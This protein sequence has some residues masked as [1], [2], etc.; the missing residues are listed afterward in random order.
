MNPP[1]TLEALRRRA[2]Q[3]DATPRHDEAVAAYERLL[4][5]QPAW[6]DG[7][8]NLGQ[9]QW[10]AR[11]FDAALQSYRQALDIGIGQPEEVHLN[12]SVI[13]AR[14]LGRIHE[15]VRELEAALACNPRYLPALLN[16]GNVCE[17]RGDRD[18]ARQCYEEA[19]RV[20]PTQALALSR[21]PNLQTLRDAEDPLI[22]R[23]DAALH[24]AGRSPAECADLGF[25][26]GKALD[27]VGRYDEAFAAYQ[28]ANQASRD[29][30]GGVRYDAAAH[31]R[32]VDRLIAAFACPAARPASSAGC[33]PPIFIC[34]MFRS[35]S[36]LI[37]QVLASH[38][39]VT[40]GG[41]LDLLPALARRHLPPDGAWPVLGDPAALQA[42]AG[43][44]LDAVAQRFPGAATLTDKR[45]DNF[46]YIGLIKTLFPDARIVHTRRNPLDNCLSVYFLHLSHA[47][48]YALDLQDTAHWY[49]QHERLMAHWQALYGADIHTVDYDAFVVD[50]EPALIELLDFCGLDW[51]PACL[52]FHE[53]RQVVQ[54]ASLWQ[55]RQPLYQRASGRWR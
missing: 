49:R 2:V 10:R 53:S 1:T 48:P 55:V 36:T 15:S 4:S 7:W 34:G 33:A 20:D 38:A 13:L 11:R 16:L 22:A 51:D 5:M 3:L 44:Y 50:P 29:A 42:L 52:S 6:A 12:R 28:A 32:F 25:G 21:L 54:T 41:E 14:H 17:Q 18:R 37:E 30:G 43:G 47:M 31:E 23:L 46:L 40:A 35:G 19:L 26:L 27:D 9:A 39:G 8:Y 45:P 24:Q